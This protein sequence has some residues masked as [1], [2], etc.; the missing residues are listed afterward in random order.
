MDCL[1][2]I[3]DTSSG[4]LRMRDSRSNTRSKAALGELMLRSCAQQMSAL[5]ASK[6]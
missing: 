2:E 5:K 6:R 3:L 4:G 1:K